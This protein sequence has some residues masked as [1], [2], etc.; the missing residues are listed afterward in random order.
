MTVLASRSSPRVWF[1]APSVLVVMAPSLGWRPSRD[2][3]REGL[4]RMIATR[5]ATPF[6]AFEVLRN[7]RCVG[8]S[9]VE[10]DRNVYCVG[11]TSLHADGGDED[12]VNAVVELPLYAV[13]MGCIGRLSKTAGRCA[14]DGAMPPWGRSLRRAR[15]RGGCRFLPDLLAVK[16][17]RPRRLL[18]AAHHAGRNT[19]RGPADSQT[20]SNECH[21]CLRPNRV[22]RRLRVH[23][24]A[25]SAWVVAPKWRLGRDNPGR[26]CRILHPRC[27][28]GFVG[29]PGVGLSA[30]EGARWRAFNGGYGIGMAVGAG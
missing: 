17:D 23:G 1:C 16:S 14:G 18:R 10:S 12:I 7:G 27:G 5:F 26:G 4:C 25:P 19:R 13:G 28:L 6:G 15:L 11:D 3:G 8:F 20:S 29:R 30:I 24:G 9:I 21:S 22:V 2:K